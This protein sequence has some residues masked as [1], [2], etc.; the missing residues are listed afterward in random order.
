MSLRPSPPK[1][2]RRAISRRGL[3]VG[4]GAGIGLV[5]AWTLWPRG[6]EPN[7]RAGPG[8]TLFNAFLKIGSDGRVIVA[9]P[10]AEIGQ[11]VTTSLPQILADELG[12]DWR[13]VAVE[14]A[15][16]SPLYANILFAQDQAGD[17]PLSG[18]AR[19]WAGETAQRSATMFTG[20]SNSVRAFEPRLRQAGATARAMLAMAAADR[21]GVEWET[22]DALGGFVV[23]GDTRLSFAELAA[24]AAEYDP[25][26]YPP[27]R[28]GNENRL[29]G[30]PLPRID[31]PSKVDGSARFAADI[32]LPGMAFASVRQGP[33]PGS[34]LVRM[35]RDEAQVPG[36]IAIVDKGSWVAAVATNW[37]AANSA[38]EKLR[39]VF[40]SDGPL[41]STVSIEAALKAALDSEG[42]ARII[43]EGDVDDVMEGETL[44]TAD[45]AVGLAA[46]A[47]I[48]PLTATARIAGDRV[49][50][51]A[52]VQAPTLARQA[53]ARAAG[54][55][56][57]SVAIYPTP[58]G[59]GYGRKLETAAVAQAVT[60][61]AE[62]KRPI[63]LMWSRVEETMQ[64]GF[65][66][67]ARARMRASIGAG[68]MISGWDALVAAPSSSAE[69]WRRAGGEAHE[70]SQADK[71]AVAG[72]RPPYSIP[73][74]AVAHAPAD[75]SVATGLWRSGAHSYT[76]FFNECFVDEIARAAGADPMTYRIPMLGDNP[77]LA[78]VLQTAA[79]LG[80]WDG[81]GRGSAMGIAC[82]QAFGSFIALLVEIEID[83]A[84]RIRVLRAMAA[85]D[86]GRV[87]NPD[88]VR[89]QI[90]GGVIHGLSGAL[91]NP[92]GFDHGQPSVHHFGG[93]GM[94]RLHDSPEVSVEI[95]PSDEPSG[96]VTELAVPP[97]APAIANALFALTGKRIRTLPL[98]L[99]TPA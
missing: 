61:A 3:L 63:Q 53:A 19:W 9:V 5:V 67:P 88:I 51:W 34:R 80:G 47:P 71:D 10:Q 46:S 58:V 20:A 17:G 33:R 84:Q 87:I 96:G 35:R 38:V 12:A 89:Q 97:V 7:L 29:V 26:R 42:A 14:S 55:P 39:P 94:P 91:A 92:I 15:P 8:E 76:G 28:G 79:S 65:R 27:L 98:R 31:V 2:S 6:Y 90:E 83:A 49:E 93:L 18:A 73:A 66:P 48:E 62:T 25:P 59:S 36:L 82:H 57:G 85:V 41:A 75:I 22:L 37:W 1:P 64:D 13:T 16:I 21:W 50:I 81:G 60:L 44:I 24:E 86:C 45:Y 72:A 99:D 52:P 4:G 69:A 95:M 40:E 78:R 43:D 70:A 32:R 11:G 68:R 30:E 56:E 77:R 74:V 23:H 54:V